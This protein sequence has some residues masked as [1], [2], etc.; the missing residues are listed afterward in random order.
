MSE[1]AKKQLIYEIAEDLIR[2]FDKEITKEVLC[3]VNRNLY[4]Y[5]VTN[6]STTIIAYDDVTEKILKIFI[7]T[8]RLEGK[9]EGT[10][11]QYYR[12][13]RCL[14]AFLNCPIKDVTTD[15]IKYYLMTM[16]VEHNL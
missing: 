2:K 6:K 11:K 14:L 15:G 9:S 4:N 13:I 1:Q 8:K 3:I 12:Q 10:L 5:D 7:G 16:K